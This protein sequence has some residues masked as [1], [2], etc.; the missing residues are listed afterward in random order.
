MRDEDRLNRNPMGRDPASLAES[1]EPRHGYGPSYRYSA[2]TPTASK[3]MN[4]CIH[5]ALF[6]AGSREKTA[7]ARVRQL[8]IQILREYLPTLR[9]ENKMRVYRTIANLEVQQ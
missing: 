2:P 5:F 3:L 6:W 9:G 1:H 4:E 8:N 7:V